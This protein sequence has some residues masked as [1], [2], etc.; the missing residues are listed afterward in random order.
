VTLPV[1]KLPFRDLAAQLS[2]I[3]S[4]SR[5]VIVGPKPGE[6]AAVI[7]FGDRYLIAKTDPITFAAERIGWYAVHI[8]ANDIAVMG[9]QP[10]WFLATVLL[11]EDTATANLV[12]TIFADTLAAC[13]EL[14]VELVG[15][16][17]EITYGLDRPIVVGQMLGEVRKDELLTKEKIVPGDCVLLTT[18]VA[19]EGTAI[20]ASEKESELRGS[21]HEEIIQRAKRY[22]FDPGISVVAD[23][24]AACRAARLHAMHDPTEGGLLA[25]LYE[26]A[27][28]GRVGLHV[29]ADQVPVLPESEVLCQAFGLDPLK[30]IASGSLLIVLPPAECDAVIRALSERGTAVA[31]IGEIKEPRFGIK[32]QRGESITDLICPERDEIA[33]LFAGD[34]QD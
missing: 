16:H 19:I 21:L 7:E 32:I 2:R 29:V 28:A 8:N 25:G 22:L 20:I 10:R 31:V 14:G 34:D 17:T 9:G 18:G 6:D 3:K 30:L 11:P 1:G 5:R 23:A 13:D 27:S 33:R 12:E 24:Q 15:G 4:R 26:L